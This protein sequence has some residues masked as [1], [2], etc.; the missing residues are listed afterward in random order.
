MIQVE[1]N[2]CVHIGVM[3]LLIVFDL[4]FLMQSILNLPDSD[5]FSKAVSTRQ[6]VD[7]VD[8]LILQFPLIYFVK[9]NK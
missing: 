7:I 9:L 5:W 2:W 6:D 3:F 1:G 8:S 4:W